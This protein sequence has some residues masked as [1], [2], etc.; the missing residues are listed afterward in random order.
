MTLES[1][2]MGIVRPVMAQYP[3][4]WAF[5]VPFIVATSFTVLNLFIGIIVSAMQAEH[6]E[7][8]SADRSALQSEQ[9]LILSELRALRADIA[10]MKE[11]GRSQ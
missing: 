7:E 9:E 5:F 1:W 10:A 6:E 3:L 8:A 2:S 4:A 11:S